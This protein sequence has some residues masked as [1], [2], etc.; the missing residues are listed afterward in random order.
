M[1]I[2]SSKK[3][4]ISHLSAF[5]HASNSLGMVPTMGALHKGHLALV[6]K[7]ISENDAVVVSIFVNPTQ[8]DNKDDLKK[9]PS[10]LDTD[11]EYLKSISD[12]LIVFT[13][14][15]TDLYSKNI[16]SKE[17][18]FNG[19][20]K[21]MEGEFRSNHFSGVATVVEKLFSIV[22][23]NRAYFGEKDFQ[24]LLIIKKLVQKM[25]IPIE[26]IG[27]PIVREP[28]GLAMSSRNERLPESL[29]NRA[30][31]I[32]KTLISAKKIFGMKSAQ[33]VRNWVQNKFDDASDFDLEYIEIC[34]QETLIPVKRKQKNTKYRA[35]IAVYISGVR[36]IDNIA[37]N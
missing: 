1:L 7:A 15:V 5:K 9:Y 34:D 3:V 29:R 12:E 35:F 19:L 8:F 4:L 30:S 2:F 23:P 28:G 20:D 14:S 17:Y 22:K 33:Y 13:P 37:L 18:E 10:T 32:Y 11:L 31:F 21:R 27:C 25:N 6:K 36:L 16:K 26:I 24:Q